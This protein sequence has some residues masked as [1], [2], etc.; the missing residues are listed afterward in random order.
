MSNTKLPWVSSN[1]PPDLRQ[2]LERVRET[3]GGNEFVRRMDYLSGTIPRNAT[4]PVDP[5]PP[6]PPG[7]TC[8]AAVTPTAP[9]GFLVDAGFTGFLLQWD[10]PG[11]CGHSHTEVYGL[12]R[13]GTSAELGV[14]NMLG[15]SAGIMY[16]HVV[17]IPEDYWCFWIKHVNVNDVE[18]PFVGAP[19]CAKTAI[20][21][22]AIIEVLKGAISE[23]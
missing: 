21:P 10:M 11:Y 5:M 22:G 17:N 18:G 19:V 8:G 20:D 3:L 16:S 14:Q 13:D 7:R 4:D 1:I 9:T 23:S 15:E 6:P 2:F 12:R